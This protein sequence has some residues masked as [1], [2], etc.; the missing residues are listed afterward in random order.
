MISIRYGTSLYEKYIFRKKL[1]TALS[2]VPYE[3]HVNLH[4]SRSHVSHGVI[5]LSSP[6]STLSEISRFSLLYLVMPVIQSLHGESPFP[7]IIN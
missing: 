7:Q 2:V 4:V 3:D 6:G 1:Q 5:D